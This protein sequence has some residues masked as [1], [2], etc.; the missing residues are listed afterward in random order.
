M[1]GK[2][3]KKRSSPLVWS[4]V[5][6]LLLIAAVAVVLQIGKAP[7]EAA[8]PEPRPIWEVAISR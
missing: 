5:L 3:G 1:R 6:T 2:H 8:E 7:D 4:F